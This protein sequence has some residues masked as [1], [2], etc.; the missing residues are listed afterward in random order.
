M[1]FAPTAVFESIQIVR[2]RTNN[3]AGPFSDILQLDEIM[4]HAIAIS[5]EIG[6]PSTLTSLRK[7]HECDRNAMQ[8]LENW[9]VKPV[10]LAGMRRDQGLTRMCFDGRG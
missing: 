4:I 1:D 6:E 10:R 3:S 2:L 8:E 9:Y 5:S 7:C